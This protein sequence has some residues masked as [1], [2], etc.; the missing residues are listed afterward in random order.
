[1]DL[2][3]TCKKSL[4]QLEWA[5]D[6]LNIELICGIVNEKYRGKCKVSK[7][8]FKGNGKKREP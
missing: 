4:N 7:K 6:H 1:M 8:Y 2:S 5:M 3:A